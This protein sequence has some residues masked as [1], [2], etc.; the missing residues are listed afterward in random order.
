MSRDIETFKRI[1]LDEFNELLSD[2][3]A[4]RK[5]RVL[6]EL[7]VSVYGSLVGDIRNTLEKLKEQSNTYDKE[8]IEGSGA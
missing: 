5:A 2:E 4:E 1:Y 7:Y 6:L 3:D 8:D